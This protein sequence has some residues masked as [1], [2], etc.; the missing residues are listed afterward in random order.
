MLESLAQ[1]MVHLADPWIWVW[2]VGG[3]LWGLVFGL[4]PGVGS[5]PVNS[6]LV[7]ISLFV[8]AIG[9]VNYF[10]LQRQRKLYLLLITVP[11]GAGVV[12]SALFIY[13]LVS[14]GLGVR[15]RA[16]SLTRIDQTSGRTVSWSRQSYYAGLAPSAGMSRSEKCMRI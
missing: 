11:L 15:A 8:V 6:F 4:I 7:L 13:A 2:T 3:V 16:R 5:A 12:T 1:A 9:P 10:L 14:D